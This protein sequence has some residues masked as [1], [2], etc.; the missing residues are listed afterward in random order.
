V[1]VVREDGCE[2]HLEEEGTGPAVLLIHGFASRLERNWRSTGW[3]DALVRG[4]FRVVAYDQRGHGASTKLY[5][6]EAY[7]TERLADDAVA[8]LDGLGITR[9]S[10]FGY[11]MGAR[12]ALETAIRSPAR[13]GALVLSGMG[14]AFRDLGGPARE[15]REAVAAALEAEDPADAPQEGLDYRSFAE[16]TGGDLRAL[17]ACWRRPSRRVTDAELAAIG[18]PTLFV[19]GDRDELAGDPRPVADRVPGSEVVILRDKGHMRAV[20]AR[21]H[22][23]AVLDFLFRRGR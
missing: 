13:V 11:S 15:G 14:S 3:I 9:S 19:V 21:E 6:A 12:V 7:A 2:L 8:V 18:C 1:I 5:D 20:G 4:G 10:L 17:A 16:K 22:R 23:A